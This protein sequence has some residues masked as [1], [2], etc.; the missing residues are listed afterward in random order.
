M[1]PI[2]VTQYIDAS[3]PP[4]D[5]VVFDEA[6]QMPV[7]DAV[8]AI[9]RGTSLVVVGDPKQLPP[10][11]FFNRTDSDELAEADE[12]VVEDME[13]ILDEC[14]AAQ[15]PEQHLRWH[16]RS[17]HESLIAFSN[18][19]YYDNGL[20]TF[21]SPQS[22]TAVKFRAAQGVYD[23]GAS[24]TNRKEADAVVKEIVRRL[25][26]PE[27]SRYSI[28]VVTFS[29]SQQALIEDLLD[30]AKD[31]DPEL[32]ALSERVEEPIFIKNL[33]SVQGDERDVILFSVCYGPDRAGK[34]SM[35]FGPLNKTGGERRL[36]VA[37]TR[38]RWEVMVFSSLTADKINL[39]RTRAAGVRDLK[40]FLDYAERGTAALSE[41]AAVDPDAGTESYFEEEV[42]KALRSVGHEVHHQIGCSG[43]R[44]DMAIVDPEKPGSYLLGIE[45]DGANYHRSRTARDRDELR[46]SVL[47]GLGWKLH[48]IWSTDWWHSPKQELEKIEKAIERTKRE[49]S[50]PTIAQ[51]EVPAKMELPHEVEE[52]AF[53]IIDRGALATLEAYEVYARHTCTTTR[54]IRS[55]TG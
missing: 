36:N 55:S 43:Y 18:K 9:A 13:S 8:G 24:R 28:G 52:D 40:Y 29:I 5:L 6:S 19:Q 49:R 53:P 4:F 26:D 37:I 42:S 17:R 39:S 46:Q 51:T 2:S 44:I 35:N 31:K 50:S 21:P 45:C 34:I 14:I 1:S 41:V 7:W 32:E 20:I 11:N 38:A 12:D 27:L 22:V 30:E 23:A 16:Y 54:A 10:T 47:E 25:K 3:Y 15:L 33:E 48:R